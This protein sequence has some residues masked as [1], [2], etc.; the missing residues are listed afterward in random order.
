V[1]NLTFFEYFPQANLLTQD[2]T[3]LTLTPN[4]T[5]A[6]PNA[7]RQQAAY[8]CPLTLKEMTGALP[9]VYLATCGCVFS[10]AGLR[11]LSSPAEIASPSTPPSDSKDGP[12]SSK[13][14]L[15]C[16]QC[17]KPYDR[18]AD[19][20]TLNP[21]LEEEAVMREAMEARRAA[22]KAATKGKKRKAAEMQNGEA[23]AVADGT[24]HKKP[25]TVIASTAPRTNASIAS[26]TRKVTESL[27][28]EESKRKGKM[29]DAV[30]SLYGPK[31]GSKKKETFMTMG[32][33]TRV[34]FSLIPRLFI[35]DAFPSMHDVHFPFW[36]SL[37]CLHMRPHNTPSFLK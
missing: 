28:E 4:P 18:L 1:R 2:V 33:F 11:A 24:E 27:A 3:T 26:V 35:I 20:R 12:S 30:A 32:T 19:V 14:T 31:D 15:L 21:G 37:L 9:F 6:D 22:K 13:Q 16:P 10:A 17:S 29:S 8:I 25:K 23:D 5:P 34:S 7:E 36:I